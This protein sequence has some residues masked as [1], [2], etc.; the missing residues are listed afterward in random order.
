MDTLIIFFEANRKIFRL[1]VPIIVKELWS[2]IQL[3]DEVHGTDFY[4][5]LGWDNILG[6]DPAEYPNAI[7]VSSWNEV[8]E[9]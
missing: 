1:D 4:D 2:A 5:R 3:Y 6:F 9:E 8:M 7:R